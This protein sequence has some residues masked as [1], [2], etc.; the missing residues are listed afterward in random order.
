M[1]GHLAGDELIQGL[2]GRGHQAAQDLVDDA[3]LQQ[4]VHAEEA[5]AQQERRIHRLVLDTQA[6]NV[7]TEQGVTDTEGGGGKLIEHNGGAGRVV[8]LVVALRQELQP[9]EIDGVPAEDAGQELVEHDV[10]HLGA[11]DL[12]GV[13]EELLSVP[14]RVDAAQPLDDPVVLAQEGGV[15]GGEAW[16]LGGAVIAAQEAQTVAGLALGMGTQRQQLLAPQLGAVHPSG[17]A[18]QLVRQARRLSIDHG[19]VQEV[20]VLVDLVT[21]PQ[22]LLARQRSHRGEAEA[23]AAGHVHLRIVEVTGGHREGIALGVHRLAG[24][25]GTAAGNGLVEALVDRREGQIVVHKL[26]ELHHH[27]GVAR[28]QV[29]NIRVN[30]GRDSPRVRQLRSRHSS[31]PWRRDAILVLG[32]QQAGESGQGLAP[33][34]VPQVVAPAGE[35][36]EGGVGIAGGVGLWAALRRLLGSAEQATDV[37]RLQGI[38]QFVAI[39]G[40]LVGVEDLTLAPGDVVQCLH[41]LIGGQL[42]DQ[43]GVGQV[44]GGQVGL[45]EGGGGAVGGTGTDAAL[46]GRKG[47]IF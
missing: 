29:G 17:E 46:C 45:A 22:R 5:V 19:A 44:Q 8:V 31:D 47:S 28:V 9:V 21:R 35:R 24:V 12:A 2:H 1:V 36:A 4:V 13:V 39:E 26:G 23:L 18:A 6:G 10:L 3:R 43:R 40:V 37:H 25:A 11:D 38:G 33:V 42:E 34:G 7:R 16:L 14:V 27:Q 32:G 41:N 20:G 30:R 15:D